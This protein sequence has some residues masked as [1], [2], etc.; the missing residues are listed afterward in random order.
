MTT[1]M[2]NILNIIS[3][4]IKLGKTFKESTFYKQSKNKKGDAVIYTEMKNSYDVYA[5]QKTYKN[6]FMRDMMNGY[7]SYYENQLYLSADGIQV[8]SYGA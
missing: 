8:T 1:E 3:S 5:K 7:L 6:E 2:S 4:D